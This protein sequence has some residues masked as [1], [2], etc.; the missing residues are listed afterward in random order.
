MYTTSGS[1]INFKH[2]LGFDNF[3]LLATIFQ[4][5]HVPL[6]T[7]ANSRFALRC[8]QWCQFFCKKNTNK[9]WKTSKK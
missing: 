7:V 3:F 4:K 1:Q 5:N 6:G 2:A 8:V 9:I